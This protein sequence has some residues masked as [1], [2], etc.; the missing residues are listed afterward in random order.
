[1]H[2]IGHSFQWVKLNLTTITQL[3]PSIEIILVRKAKAFALFNAL[4]IPNCGN[5]YAHL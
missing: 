3:C 5:K 4:L 1:M 2:L